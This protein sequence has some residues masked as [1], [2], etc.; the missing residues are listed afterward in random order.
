M[1]LQSELNSGDFF[2]SEVWLVCFHVNLQQ[3]YD[4]TSFFQLD[5]SYAI[6][7][8]NLSKFFLSKFLLST[9]LT[10]WHSKD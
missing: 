7:P 5:A 3:L 9:L 6:S 8:N 2:V 4:K 10:S 1:S